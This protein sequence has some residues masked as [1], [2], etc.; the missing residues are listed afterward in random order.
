MRRWRRLLLMLVAALASMGLASAGDC[1]RTGSVCLDS[2]PCKTVS[3]QQVCLAQHGLSCWEYEDS[4]TCIK[5]D[6]VN[7]CQPLINSQPQCWQSNSQCTQMDTILNTGCM[8]L[9]QTW[10]CNDPSRSTPANTIRLDSAYTLVSSQYNT[11]ACSAPGPNCSIAE[12]KCVQTTPDSPLPASVDPAQAA[13]DGCY[14]RQSTYA[15]Y[16]T[17]PAQLSSC[18]ASR[19]TCVDTS[20]SKTINGVTVTLA[21]AGGCWRYQDDCVSPNSIDYCAPLAA[22]RETGSTCTQWD[23]ALSTG[24]MK[25]QKTYR[26]GDPSMP[27]PANTVKL[28]D[29]YTLVSSGYDPTPCAS[30][31]GNPNCALAESTCTSTTPPSL[32]AGIDP[33]QVASDGC[34]QRRNQYAC[35]SGNIDTSDCDRYALNPNCTLQTSTCDS[36]DRVSGQCVFEEKAYR[37]LSSPAQTRTV[38]D[39]ATRAFCANGE[40]SDT[41]FEPDADF[42]KAVAAMEAA[43]EAGT[44]IDPDTLQLF[45]GAGSKCTKKLAGLVNCCKGGSSGGGGM[46]NQSLAGQMLSNAGG[47]AG[48]VGSPYMYDAMFSS[49]LPWLMDKAVDAWASNAWSPTFN[50]SLSFYGVTAQVGGAVPAGTTTLGA[51]GNVQ[52]YFNP[53][54]FYIAIAVMVIQELTS[55]EQDDQLTAMKKSQNLCVALGSYCSSKI[56]KV[57]VEKKEGYCCFNSRLARIIQEQGRAQLGKSWGSPESPECSGFTTAEFER[58]DFSQIDLTEFIHEIQPKAM[59]VQALAERMNSRV[60]TMANQ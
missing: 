39:C 26:C 44:Y 40:C 21:Q 35:L 37:C 51:V 56:L 23:T 47:F 3:G 10:R 24:C 49:D 57:C 14:K 9:T 5:P 1:K 2:T 30:L 50:P 31:D 46:S 4:Y 17:P 15:C 45:T 42:G 12:N 22:C 13:P 52:L 60:Q 58:L 55:C 20:P 19:S 59:D 38:T 8:R 6:A 53:T 34:Y 27:T 54:T 18:S 36:D 16:T 43:R 29:T 41:G 7:Y 48:S 33:A 32:P 11:S 28:S 25:Y